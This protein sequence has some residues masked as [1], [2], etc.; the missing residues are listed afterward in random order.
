MAV[1]QAYTCS[2]TLHDVGVGVVVQ[3]MQS[4]KAELQPGVYIKA[5]GHMRQ[6]QGKVR[7]H[8]ICACCT[9]THLTFHTLYKSSHLCG[10]AQ[11]PSGVCDLAG[12]I[13]L[14][15]SPRTGPYAWVCYC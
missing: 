11:P 4:K 15:P 2:C 5:H 3:A 10:P 9:S 8:M 7:A 12:L 14:P 13:P 1:S 6:F